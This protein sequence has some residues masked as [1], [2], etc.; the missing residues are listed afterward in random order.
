MDMTSALTTVDNDDSFLGISEKH[1][2]SDPR[3]KIVC[4]DG[5]SFLQSLDDE[6]YD[7]I[8]QIHR[9]ESNDFLKRHLSWDS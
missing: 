8:L 5:D 1:L 7:Y 2:G 6:S 4:S 9:L 3:L